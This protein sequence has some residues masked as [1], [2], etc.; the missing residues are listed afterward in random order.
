MSWTRSKIGAHIKLTVN[1]VTIVSTIRLKSL[2]DVASGPVELQ[3]VTGVDIALW[4]GLEINIAIIC[5]SV[6]ALRA[7]AHRLFRNSSSQPTYG[8]GNNSTVRKQSRA[9]GSMSGDEDRAK[10]SLRITVRESIEMKRYDGDDQGSESDLIIIQKD[11]FAPNAS[12]QVRIQGDGDVH[13]A[14]AGV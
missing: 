8:Y 1:R 9:L 7:F 14:P 5:G 2:Y 4:S 13:S 12:R 3:T 10:G 6:P 11:A